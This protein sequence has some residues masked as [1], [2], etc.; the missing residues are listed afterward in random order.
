MNIEEV[1]SEAIRIVTPSPEERV[2]VIDTANEVVKLLTNGLSR[3][4]YRDFTVSIQGSIAKDTWL[5]GDRDIDIFIILPRDYIDRI[6]DG[7]ITNDLI[8]IAVENDIKWSIRYAQHPYIQLLINE[9]EIDV[10][11]CIRISP[12]EKPLT[13]ADRTPL[14][15]EFVNG[16]LGHRAT[17]VR[18]LKAFFKSVGVYGAEI[19]VQGFSGYVSEL[20]II[21]YGSFLNTIKAIS[22]WST[23][24]VF[25]DMTGA[26]NERDAI[27]KFKSPVIIIDPVDPS[28]NA[29]ASISREVLATA[30]AASRE[31]LRNPRVEFFMRVHKA[32]K[33][34]WVLPTVVMRMPYPGNTSPDVVWGEIRKLLS[35][36]NRNLKKLDFEVIRS[37]AWSDDKSVILLIITLSELELPPYELHEGPPVNSNAVDGFI[38]KYVNEPSVVGPFIR[39]SRWFVVRKRRFY[40]AVD[41]IKYLVSTISLKHLRASITNAMYVK[42]RSVDDLNNFEQGERAIIEEF[43]WSRPWWLT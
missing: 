7:S 23:R 31:F 32:V 40:D 43:L 37:T 6:R 18:L 36:L 27:R 1:L 24:H 25:I 33:P 28:R 11:P 19:K 15:T 4:G 26:Y 30:I 13:A 29:A 8:G 10:V 5:P 41:A 42:I 9:F 21:Y 35:S 22:N 34:T 3:R 38:R 17:D 2:R 16:R 20:L 14:H 12:G 39:G